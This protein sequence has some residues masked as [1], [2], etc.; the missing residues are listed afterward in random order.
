MRVPLMGVVEHDRVV[1]T[2]L[3]PRDE[4]MEPQLFHV[5]A[6]PMASVGGDVPH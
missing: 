1:V 6:F 4:E 3:R 2:R 5:I